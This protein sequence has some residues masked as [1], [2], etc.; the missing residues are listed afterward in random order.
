MLVVRVVARG[1]AEVDAV[2]RRAGD[3]TQE[4][5]VHKR[6]KTQGREVRQGREMGDGRLVEWDMYTRE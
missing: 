1:A 2:G 6:M 5:P 4:R 3:G